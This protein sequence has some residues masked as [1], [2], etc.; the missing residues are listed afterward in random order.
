MHHRV[1]SPTP[2]T[3]AQRLERLAEVG[4]ISRQEGDRRV[5]TGGFSRR[6]PVDVEHLIAMRLQI[7][8]DAAAGLAAATGD[9]DPL[10]HGAIRLR[11]SATAPARYRRRLNTTTSSARSL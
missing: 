4:Q 2:G 5:G 6:P 7:A 11:S 3:G 1:G 8:D 10:A 9:D